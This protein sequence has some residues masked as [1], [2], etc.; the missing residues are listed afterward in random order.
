MHGESNTNEDDK[1][2]N[3]D[4]ENDWKRIDHIGRPVGWCVFR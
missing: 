3:D 1:R 4:G 2:D